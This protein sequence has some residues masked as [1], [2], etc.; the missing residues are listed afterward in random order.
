MA[1]RDVISWLM[2]KKAEL[3]VI[4]LRMR[5]RRALGLSEEPLMEDYTSRKTDYR[6]M[7]KWATT[8]LDR[9]VNGEVST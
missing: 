2:Q 1:R 5:E 7:R 3:M 6:Q 8:V 9:A 4:L